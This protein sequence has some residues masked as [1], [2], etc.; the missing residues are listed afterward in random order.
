MRIK[1]VTEKLRAICLENNIYSSAVSN[2]LIFNVSADKIIRLPIINNSFVV[3]ICLRQEFYS[4]MVISYIENGTIF[5]YDPSS[6]ECCD[7]LKNILKDL[8]SRST[9][10]NI[11]SNKSSQTI[12]CTDKCINLFIRLIRWKTLK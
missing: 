2:F 5:Y 4:H 3:P 7:T 11:K 1:T 12:D 6:N 10:V 9:F 8:F